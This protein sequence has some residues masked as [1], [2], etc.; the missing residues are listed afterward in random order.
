METL[1]ERLPVYLHWA[2]LFILALTF[3]YYIIGVI[4]AIKSPLSRL[5]GPWYAPLTTLRLNYAFARGT[6]WKAVEKS[7]TQYGPIFRLGPRQVWISDKEAI[8]AILMT[9]DLPKVTM[10]AEISRDRTS[11]GLF[12]EIRPDPH[13]RLKKFLS[14]AFTIAYVDGLEFLF[15][16]CVGD[17][18]NRYVDLMSCPS[19]KGEKAPVVT[20]LM[21]DLHSLALD[22]M[23]ECSFGNGFGQTNKNRKLELEFDE[24]VWRTIPTAIFR[25]MTRRY[26]FVYIKRLLRRLGLNVEFDWPREMI[27]AISAVASHRK[28]TPKSVRPDLLQHLL[29]NGE[30]PDSGVKMGTR[31][32]V[33]QMAEI[34]LAGSETTSG[35]IACFFLEILRNPEIKDKLMKSLPI[36]HPSDPIIPSKTVRTSPEYEYLEACIKEVLRL[37]PIASEMG[38]RTGKT[39]IE[40]MGFHLPAHTIV[41]ASYRQLHRDPKYWVEPL[42]FWPERWLDPRPSDVPAPDM[43][44]YYPFSA[45]KHSCIGKNFAMAEIRM[46]TANIFSR[47]DL[48][49]VPG[50]N[51]DYRQY[52]T[53]QFEKGSW[54]AFLT[55]RY[56]LSH[57]VSATI[58]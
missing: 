12:G 51:I 13:K 26:Q 4:K 40:L 56:Q 57:P 16:K 27:A 3:I 30:R 8:K 45:G 49:E 20:D 58:A 1:S 5:P 23:G 11:P 32:V 24:D 6:I 33:D 41:S 18:I 2:P 15:S 55:P 52:I 14:P 54:K 39:P 7:H 42:R 37:H 43:Q 19:P 53:M 34:L 25:G 10:Y 21:E 50:Q 17:L 48:A 9:V 46:L 22:I 36:L 35:T 44:A 29:E 38:R 31:E 28:A 47:F